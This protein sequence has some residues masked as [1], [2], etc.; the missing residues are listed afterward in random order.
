MA[1]ESTGLVARTVFKTAEAGASRLVGSIPTLS[2][3][4]LQKPAFQAIEI[5]HAGL[6]T[7]CSR[8]RVRG[9]SVGALNSRKRVEWLCNKSLVGE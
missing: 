4:I 1:W 2:R 7:R 3:H 5:V 8:E 9:C 6:L